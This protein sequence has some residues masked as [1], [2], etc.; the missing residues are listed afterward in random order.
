MYIISTDYCTTKKNHI[1]IVFSRSINYIHSALLMSYFYICHTKNNINA[2]IE[3]LSEHANCL[4][5]NGISQSKYLMF[6]ML[7]K[8]IIKK[9][10]RKD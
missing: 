10:G 2:N 5:L 6:R 8:K 1:Y 9:T 3:K 4:Y 7:I